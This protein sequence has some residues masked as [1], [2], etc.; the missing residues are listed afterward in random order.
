LIECLFG[1]RSQGL[2]TIDFSHVDLS[3]GQQRPEQHGSGV[4]GRQHGLRLDAPLELLVQPLDRG[5]RPRVMTMTTGE[6][7][8][9]LP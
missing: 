7:T 6:L 3:G 8:S 2:P 4:G 5:R 9:R 1:A